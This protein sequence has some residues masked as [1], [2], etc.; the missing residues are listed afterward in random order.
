MDFVSGLPVTPSTK[1]SVWVIVDQFSKSAYFLAMHTNYSLQKLAKL[2]TAEIVRLYGVPVS[3]ISDRDPRFTLRFWKNLK[4]RG[5]KFQVGDKVFLKVSPW[6]NVLRFRRKGKLS[7]R[8]VRPYEFVE[9][10]GSVV[11]QL[12]LSQ[13][14]EQTHDVFHVS[15]LWKYHSDP[16]HAVPVEEVE[17][18][19]NLTYKE[20]PV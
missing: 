17:V 2:Y 19:P 14:L 12:K 15:M 1:D 20:E 9:R 10:I 16:S 6:K 3:I 18:R 13:E 7:P 11:Y 8:Y 4:H 5:I